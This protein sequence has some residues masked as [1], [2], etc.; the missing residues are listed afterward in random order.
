MQ[1]AAQTPPPPGSAGVEPARIEWLPGEVVALVFRFVDAKTLM[2]TVPS[3]S[4]GGI[5]SGSGALCVGVS[6]GRAQ[7]R[8]LQEAAGQQGSVG[9]HFV[10]HTQHTGVRGVAASLLGAHGTNRA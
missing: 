8:T 6:H 4:V 10:T 7:C 9:A 2:M 1:A 3:V 5:R